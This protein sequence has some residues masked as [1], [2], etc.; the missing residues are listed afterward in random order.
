LRCGLRA[1]EDVGVTRSGRL[2]EGLGSERADEVGSRYGSR[3]GAMG[4][5]AGTVRM[6]RWHGPAD[7]LGGLGDPRAKLAGNRDGGV[8]RGSRDNRL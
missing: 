1:D 6:R 8:G 4:L 2:G 5:E 7:G 3:R